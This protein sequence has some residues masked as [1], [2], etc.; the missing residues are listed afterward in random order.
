MDRRPATLATV[1]AAVT[2]AGFGAGCGGGRELVGSTREPAP[3]VD[4]VALPDVSRDGEPFELRAEPGGL[5]VV[6]FGYTNCPDICPTTMSDLRH[7]MDELGDDASRI[8]VAMVTVDPARDTDVLA[9]YVQDF[10]P[11]AH[12]LA[13]DDAVALRAV[14]EPFGVSYDV[15]V[16]DGHTEVGHSSQLFAV[17]ET[18]TLLVTWSF[19]TRADDLVADLRTLLPDL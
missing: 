8:D 10:V 3:R 7:A 13:T 15:Q 11:D 16:H 5:L 12:A 1:V 17:D 2:I 19:G 9:D 18:G 6:F 14:A 4:A